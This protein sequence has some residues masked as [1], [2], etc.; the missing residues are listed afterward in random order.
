[1]AIEF[2]DVL[3]YLGIDSAPPLMKE[4]FNYP[5]FEKESDCYLRRDRLSSISNKYDLLG[6][7]Q[8][9]ALRKA[10]KICENKM[11]RIYF[12]LCVKYLD[13]IGEDFDAALQIEMPKESGCMDATDVFPLFV[14]FHEFSKAERRYKALGL[15]DK[16]IW[17]EIHSIGQRFVSYSDRHKSAM[18]IPYAYIWNMNYVYA[19]IV[20]FCGYN[21]EVNVFN[22]NAVCL[23]NIATGELKVL[24]VNTTMHRDGFVLGTDGY[25]DTKGAWD[26]TYE[27]TAD[28]F[29]GFAANDEGIVLN[30]KLCFPKTEWKEFAKKGDKL[31]SL[32]I[33]KGADLTKEN[34]DMVLSEGSRKA[35]EVFGETS[36]LYCF[37]WLL[38][39]QFE[40]IL[41]QGSNIVAFGKRFTRFP[42]LCDG[43]G[44]FSNVFSENNG[45]YDEL[46]ENTSLERAVKKHYLDGKFLY[47]YPGIIEI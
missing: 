20:N 45:E 16:K 38:E 7:W 32:H 43:K 15:D 13:V 41:K 40:K 5:D 47:L 8:E 14:L 27:E 11:L 28:A 33:P 18:V 10:E 30:K 29:V 23:K 24:L 21:F 26:A 46:P 12:N 42:V 39:P 2:N 19:K 44:V 34:L 37:S 1:M 9:E 4:I 17:Q 35:K 3:E 6:H 31:L 36:I 25:T 22:H